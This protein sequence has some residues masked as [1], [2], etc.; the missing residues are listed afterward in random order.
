MDQDKTKET[1][2][3]NV[4]AKHVAIWLDHAEA[5]VFHIQAEEV[6][7]AT[8]FAASEKSHRRHA[9]EHDKAHPDDEKHFFHDIARSIE[10]NDGVLVVGPS[11]AKLAF[12]RYLH[13]HDQAVERSVVGVETVD[14]PTD[15]Q[16]VAY[17]RAYFAPG[18]RPS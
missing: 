16:I 2:I 9:R 11:T 8:F 17:A 3:A 5:R 1:P 7:E 15:K 12:L 10:G 14:H 18:Q 13:T 6:E 4:T